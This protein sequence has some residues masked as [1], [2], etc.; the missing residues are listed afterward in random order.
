LSWKKTTIAAFGPSCYADNFRAFTP[1]EQEVL[2]EV[3]I[4]RMSA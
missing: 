4:T 2:A 1:D 3:G